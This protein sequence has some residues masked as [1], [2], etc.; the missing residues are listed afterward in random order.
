MLSYIK[1]AL[2]AAGLAALTALLAYNIPGWIDGSE[3]FQWRSVL[4]AVVSAAIAGFATFKAT[5]GP[6]PVGKAKA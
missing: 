3:T 5:N 4:A 2:V 1:K 6:P